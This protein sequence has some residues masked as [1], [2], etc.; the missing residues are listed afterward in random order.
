MMRQTSNAPGSL[1]RA[2][3][4]DAAVIVP[5]WHGNAAR[6]LAGLADQVG[7]DF[8]VEIV[9]GIH[10]A[11]TARNI[12]AARTTSEILVFI[13]DDAYLG[14]V[15]VLATM[16]D[17]LL[18][19]PTIGVVGP[20]KLLPPEASW[21][22]RRIAV[23][24]PR[25]VY[26]IAAEDTES[27]P[28]LDHYG[29]TGITTTCCAM[30]R[31]VFEEVGGFDEE[32]ITGEDTEFFYRLRRAGYRFVIPRDCWVHHPVPGS[33]RVLLRKSFNSGRGHAREARR[34]PGRNMD[35]VPLD[36]WY[37]KLFVLLAPLLFMPS[38]FV[39][40]YFDP[41]RHVRLGFRPLKAI[42]TYA[43]LYGYTRAWF[44]G[45]R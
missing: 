25:W 38:L 13:D 4:P 3:R 15:R 37:G 33:L 35:V 1:D 12:G 6:L 5:S 20:S 31:S 40:F 17:T 18:A 9:R 7:Q 11:G 24:V 39:S 21:L 34:A 2:V 28:P 14:H 44:R 23:E 10:P 43:T 30:R 45:W 19:D 16:V 36:R 41:K 8:T 42:S 22:Q 32:L 27:N 29:F 26:P